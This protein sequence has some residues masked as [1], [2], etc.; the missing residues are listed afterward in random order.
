MIYIRKYYCCAGW[1]YI[2][3][4]GEG[5]RVVILNFDHTF[6][7]KSHLIATEKDAIIWA[8]KEERDE[9]L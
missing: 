2:T 3:R 4:E 9:Q 5:F 6:D 1:V 8:E 7:R